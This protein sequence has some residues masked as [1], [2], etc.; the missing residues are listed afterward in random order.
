AALSLLSGGRLL[1]LFNTSLTVHLWFL[2]MLLTVQALLPWCLRMDARFGLRVVVV[3]VLLAG[4][5]D[6]VR[7][8][9]GSPGGLRWLGREAS[10][11]SPGIAWLNMLLVWLLPQQL[12]IAWKRG[13]F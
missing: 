1:A 6:V 2:L 11:Q 7:A 13:R 8:G 5:L 3:L 4:L 10:A 12:G 9:I